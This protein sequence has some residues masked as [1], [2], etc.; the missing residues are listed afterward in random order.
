M[1]K[2]EQ[3]NHPPRNAMLSLR[4]GLDKDNLLPVLIPKEPNGHETMD[5]EALMRWHEN[6]YFMLREMNARKTLLRQTIT[7]VWVHE[8]VEYTEGMEVWLFPAPVTSEGLYAVGGAV[9]SHLKQMAVAFLLPNHHVTRAPLDPKIQVS[10]LNLW[11]YGD[12]DLWS[13]LGKPRPV[14]PNGCTEIHDHPTNTRGFLLDSEFKNE[15][16][17]TDVCAF[18]YDLAI[19]HQRD[20]SEIHLDL[21]AVSLAVVQQHMTKSP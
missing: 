8:G 1:S 11:A 18:D 6:K 17:L 10:R 13:Q 3:A 9:C 12:E 21:D 20:L 15:D 7:G 19:L 2:F 14:S 4:G 5:P 16:G